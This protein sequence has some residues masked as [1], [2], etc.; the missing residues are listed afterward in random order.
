MLERYFLKPQTLDRIRTLWLGDSLERYVTWLADQGY[1]AR[2]VYRRVPLL[3]QFGE[4]AREHGATSF[5]ELPAHVA[6]FVEARL[7]SRPHQRKSGARA[8]GNEIRGPIRQFLHLLTPDHIQGS[9]RGPYCGPPFLRS[10]PGFFAYLRDERGLQE[11]SLQQYGFHLRR[12]EQY[13]ERID[14]GDLASLSPAIL[15]AFVA[16]CHL[17]GEA[18]TSGKRLGRSSMI[19][20]CCSLRVF[21][22]YL[23]REGLVARDL[24]PAVETPRQYRLADLPR[25]ISWEEVRQVLEAVD[26]RTAVGRRDYAMLLLMI[27]YGLRGHEVAEVRLDDLDWERERLRV[28]ERKAGHSTAYPLSS[29]VGEAIL[30]YLQ[31]GRPQSTDRHLFL[32]VLA[33]FMPLRGSSVS[34]QAT[35]HL[36]RAGIQV[37]RPGSHTFRHS[38]IQRLV[39]AELSF[40]TIGDYVG[41]RSPSS[42]QGYTKIAVETLREVALGDG[43]EIA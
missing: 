35:R 2:N 10:A 25:S 32:R 43:E 16:D 42:T 36:R 4:F 6:A 29:V 34:N 18:G 14:A 39:D 7:R 1:G 11:G 40:K 5:E 17:T 12:L 41:H 8:A 38:C 13:L 21:L 23:Y 31:H 26:R 27:T 3:V 30:D 28:P 19:G 24:S 22:R 33:P 9:G 37:A 20:L 15:S